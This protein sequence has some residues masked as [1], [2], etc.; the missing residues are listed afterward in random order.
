MS[1]YDNNNPN[2]SYH[3]F[4]FA[5]TNTATAGAPATVQAH[6]LKDVNTGAD[7]PRVY[8]SP[9]V[10]IP[11]Y[12]PANGQYGFNQ[13]MVYAAPQVSGNTYA[14]QQQ[15]IQQVQQQQ[16]QQQPQQQHQQQQQAQQQNYYDPNSNNYYIIP[17]GNPNPNNPN[18]QIG[19]TNNLGQVNY[20]STGY[21]QYHPPP[22]MQVAPGL[23]PKQQQSQSTG[24]IPTVSSTSQQHQQVQQQAQQQPQQ[25]QQQSQQVSVSTANPPQSITNNVIFPNFCERLQQLL[26]PPPLSRADPRPELGLSLSNKRAKR[27]SKFSKQ[28]DDLIVSLKKKGKSWVEIA[29]ISQVGSYLAARN[30]YQVIVGQQGNNNSSSWDN[31]DKEHLQRILDAGEIEKWRFISTELNKATSKNFTDVECREIVRMLFWANPGQFSVNEDTINECIKEKKLAEKSVEQRE[32]HGKKKSEGGDSSSGSSS[33]SKKRKSSS[34]SE[35]KKEES[36]NANSIIAT[37]SINSIS[38]QINP[39]PAT[40]NVYYSTQPQL[41]H[42]AYQRYS[43]TPNTNIN[44]NANPAANQYSYPKHFY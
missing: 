39:A 28:Q 33:S 24:S 1:S 15:Q 31:E 6:A 14:A 35:I 17:P 36:N 20:Y 18:N 27:K 32:Q 21:G 34:G 40:S 11:S 4:P 3:Q 16:Q 22:Q 5:Q 30:R 43:V 7:Q 9:S 8:A 37:T 44:N 12:Y 42:G 38:N 2:N 29:E 10:Q 26:P 19:A 41:S 13:A 25:S 23:P